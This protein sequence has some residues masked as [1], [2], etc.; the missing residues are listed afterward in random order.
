MIE[1]GLKTRIEQALVDFPVVGL[2]GPRQVGKTTLAK[3]ISK[4]LKTKVLY[5]DLERLSD[6]QKLSNPELYLEG[7]ADA[8]VI[9]D[10]VQRKPDLFPLLRSLVDARARNGQFMILGSASPD[11]KRQASESLAGRVCYFELTGFIPTEVGM[12]T[13]VTDALWNRGGFPRSFLA[14]S[15]AVSFQWRE[16]FIQTFLE[17]DIPNLGVN[18]TTTT[19]MR[20][21]QMVA[22][23]HGQ[24]W[25]ASKIAASLGVTSPTTRRYLDLLQDTFMVRQLMPYSSNLKKRLVK[26][27]KIYLRDSGLLH[28]LLGI[29]SPE[30]LLGHPSA[31]ASFEGWII[32]QIVSIVPSHWTL[33][34]YRTS[35]GAE[36]D[37]VLQPAQKI[38]PIV[39]EIKHALAPKLTKGFWSALEDVQPQKG[40]VVY[41][42]KEAYPVADNVQILPMA[43]LQNILN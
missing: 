40:Y 12:E 29:H 35:A 11:L 27:P 26:S 4:R 22:H 18:T 41:P 14:R 23:C 42:G 3:M 19:L 8:L 1:R 30:A 5:L 43:Q 31:G 17:R 34:F 21:W 7:T 20:F 37:L 28:A 16:S 2:L 13:N 9:L 39:V 6:L 32:E 15:D 33:S 24:L 25:N 10:E 38:P 36:L